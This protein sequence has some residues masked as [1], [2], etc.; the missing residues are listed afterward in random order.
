MLKTRCTIKTF[1][2]KREF[3]RNKGVSPPHRRSEIR[4]IMGD[5]NLRGNA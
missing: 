1:K 2:C 3:H 5:N 4:V